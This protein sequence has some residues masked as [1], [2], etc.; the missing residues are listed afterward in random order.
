[1]YERL[2]ELLG[3]IGNVLISGYYSRGAKR[4]GPVPSPMGCF[5]TTHQH[6]I[7]MGIQPRLRRSIRGGEESLEL[8]MIRIRSSLFLLLVFFYFFREFFID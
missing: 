4:D 7:L 5:V 6:P 3:T 8:D 2:N 1:M